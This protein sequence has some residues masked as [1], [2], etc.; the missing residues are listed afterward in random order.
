MARGTINR[1]SR[2]GAAVAASPEAIAAGLTAEEGD[3]Q[4][5]LLLANLEDALRMADGTATYGNFLEAGIARL[6]TEV[7]R[8]QHDLSVQETVLNQVESFVSSVSGVSLDEESTN[9]IAFQR[10]FEASSKMVS[11]V[12]EMLQELLALI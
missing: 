2:Q 1:S 6:A 4:N 10:A 5:A 3:N 9:L 8:S 11:V 7:Q 12:D